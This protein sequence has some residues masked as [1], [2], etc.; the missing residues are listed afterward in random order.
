MMV[1]ELYIESC[2]SIED[3]PE[4]QVTKYLTRNEI[5]RLAIY[6]IAKKTNLGSGYYRVID[7]DWNEITRFY[8]RRR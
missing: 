7:E 2:D 3:I 4:I 1:T 8:F 5:K 6:N